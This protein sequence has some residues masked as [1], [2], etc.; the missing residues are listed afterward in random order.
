MLPTQQQIIRR[1]RGLALA[2]L[3]LIAVLVTWAIQATGTQTDS[4][5]VVTEASTDSAAV[6]T[7]EPTECGAGLVKLEAFIGIAGETRNSFKSD[8]QPELWYQIT[9]TGIQECLFNIGARATFFTITSGDQTYWSSKDCDRTGLDDAVVTLAPNQ[10]L[11][12]QSSPWLKV[13]SSGTGCGE[14]QDLVPTGGASYHLKA[15]VNGVISE[16]T[17]QF[18][19]N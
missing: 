4:A 10:S 16:N 7:T 6:T 2:A 11:K 17:Q 18:L 12:S 15:E 13:R 8:E 1:R 14:G 5:A 19:L 3:A 9:N